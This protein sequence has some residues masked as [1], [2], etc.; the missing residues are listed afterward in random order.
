M[1]MNMHGDERQFRDGDREREM[2]KHLTIAKGTRKHCVQIYFDADDERER[3]AV[4]YCG[5]H[6]STYRG[7]Y[8]T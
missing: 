8:N 7:T 4:G 5:P 6:L 2:Q 1:T 3:F